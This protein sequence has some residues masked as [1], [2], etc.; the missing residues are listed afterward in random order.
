MDATFPVR[1]HETL[2]ERQPVSM[3]ELNPAAE[4]ALVEKTRIARMGTNSGPSEVESP[5]A[6]AL[7]CWHREALV[8]GFVR[9]QG[10][11]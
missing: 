7:V 10:W 8:R 11:R 4:V 1:L 3:R 9:V 6:Q 2:S 5:N